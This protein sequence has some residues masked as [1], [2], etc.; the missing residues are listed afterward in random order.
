M[1]TEALSKN[2]SFNT[3]AVCAFFFFAYF[4]LFLRI[5]KKKKLINLSIKTNL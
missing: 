3:P 4:F 2:N 5:A 1:P